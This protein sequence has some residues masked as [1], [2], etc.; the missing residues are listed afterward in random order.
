M[1]LQLEAK[2]RHNTF[3]MTSESRTHSKH[4]GAIKAHTGYA[5]HDPRRAATHGQLPRRPPPPEWDSQTASHQHRPCRPVA[6]T[7]CWTPIILRRSF[8]ILLYV[9]SPTP[10]TR[11]PWRFPLGNPKTHLRTQKGSG[12]CFLDDKVTSRSLAISCSQQSPDQW[13]FPSEE[14]RLSNTNLRKGKTLYL[15]LEIIPQFK[16]SWRKLLS[17]TIPS[18]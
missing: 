10:A 1:T 6:L 8:K 2:K 5:V 13:A 3:E 15:Y 7:Y 14:L 12:L 9:L 17:F 11:H 18:S 16:T 4:N